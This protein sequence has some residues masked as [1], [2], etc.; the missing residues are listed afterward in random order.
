MKIMPVEESPCGEH[1]GANMNREVFS[2]IC[3]S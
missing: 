1:L 2:G 3:I